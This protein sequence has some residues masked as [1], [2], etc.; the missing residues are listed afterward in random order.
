MGRESEEKKCDCTSSQWEWHRRRRLLLERMKKRMKIK[1]SEMIRCIIVSHFFSMSTASSFVIFIIAEHRHVSYIVFRLWLSPCL[2]FDNRHCSD[3][4][5]PQKRDCYVNSSLLGHFMA[6]T[7]WESWWVYEFECNCVSQ[8]EWHHQFPENRQME[9]SKLEDENTT[10]EIEFHDFKN[11]N[12]YEQSYRHSR[13]FW[14]FEMHLL[15]DFL[16]LASN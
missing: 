5:V 7:E 3:R 1:K 9:E 8:G 15:P 4:S 6:N 16:V 14:S 13:E 12:D 11:Q 10:W 2:F